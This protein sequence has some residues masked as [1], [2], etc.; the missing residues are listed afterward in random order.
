MVIPDKEEFNCS[1]RLSEKYIKSR[2]PEFYSKLI[3]DEVE[4]SINPSISE[5]LYNYY[6]S[7]PVCPVCSRYTKF[8]SFGRGYNIYCSSSCCAS[9][10]VRK[11]KSEQTK[12]ERYGDPYYT[13]H[14]KSEQTKLERY[15]DPYYSDKEKMKFTCLKRYGVENVSQSDVV[16][17]KVKKTKQSLN[18]QD[19]NSKISSTWALKSDDEKHDITQKIHS[20]KFKRYG[21]EHY[22]NTSKIKST[23]IERYGVDNPLKSEVILNKV[24]RTNLEKYGVEFP[25][26]HP[27]LKMNNTESR[28]KY[29]IKEHGLVDI[30]DGEWICKC[31]HPECNKCENRTY[32]INSSQY[33]A[34][35]QYNIEPCTNLLP[36]NGSIGNTGTGIELFVRNILDEYNIEYLSN[37][38]SIIP[39]QELDIYIPSKKIAIECNGIYWHSKY[40][41]KY[42]YNKY[43]SCEERGIQLLSIWEDWIYTKPDI[44]KSLILSKLGIY[45]ERIYARKC[46]VRDVG[47]NICS[48][49]LDLNHIQGA[50]KTNVRKGLYF[51]GNLVAVMTFS[52]KSKLSGSKKDSDEWVLSRFCSLLGTQV[53]GG[54]DKLLKSFVKTYQPSTI[55]S[56]ASNDISNGSLYKRL[57]F[58]KDTVTQAYWYIQK[59]IFKRYHRSSFSKTRLE[60]MGYDISKTEGEIMS[61]LP[62]YKIYDSGHT[63]YIKKIII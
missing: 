31:P 35:K 21:N 14:A 46:E 6:N 50:A 44:I 26:Q 11:A 54:A 12:L 55:I 40:E 27:A 36:I 59:D 15:G 13:N 48:R 53:L 58:D 19:I 24:K 8:L 63:K 3:T 17:D 60:K 9:D 18:Q 32:N 30:I 39:P 37:I 62:Y 16:K 45:N 38:R 28:N 29:Y 57:G 33:H 47:S 5:R 49:F 42:H 41:P 61:S 51:N 34:R 4:G 1:K 43:V 25:M 7:R 2:F 56:F 22:N 52:H 20:T 23:C 10:P